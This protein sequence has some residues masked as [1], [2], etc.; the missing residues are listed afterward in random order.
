MFARLRIL[1]HTN[2]FY[3]SITITHPFGEETF[4]NVEPGVR[5]EWW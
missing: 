2:K 3:E 1:I 5:S 4:D